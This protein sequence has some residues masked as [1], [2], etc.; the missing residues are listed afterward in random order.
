MFFYRLISVLIF[1][2][3]IPYSLFRI[4]KGKEDK[5]RIKE[6]FG[7]SSVKRPEGDLIWLHAVSV[8]ETNSVLILLDEILQ[9]DKKVNVLFT[10]TTLTSAAILA[11]KID[12]YNGRVIHQF[13]PFDSYFIIKKFLNFWKVKTAIFVESEIW[14]NLL[15]ESSKMGIK[16]VLVN[17]RMSDNSAQKWRLAKKIGFNIF[18]CFKIIFAQSLEDK[19]RLEKLTNN[20]VL[21]IGNLKSQARDL[22]VNSAELEKLKTQ[23]GKR[24][25]FLAAST[26][27]GE[28]QFVIATHQELK[29]DFPD[30]LTIL[31]PRHPNRTEEIKMLF[32]G[33][34]FS[35]RS[36]N[37][38]IKDA[39]EIYLANTLGELGTFYSLADFAFI[40]GSLSAVGGHNPFEPIKLEC[41]VISGSHVFNFKEIYANLVKYEACVMIDSADQ[42]TK[43]VREFLSNKKSSQVF[44]NKA[45]QVIATTGNIAAEIVKIIA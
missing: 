23:I 34:S 7:F 18:D 36:K 14:P 29:K 31:V 12:G 16:N 26:H 33:L 8:G 42:L 20:K 28:E 43:E 11:K 4:K 19:N 45:S 13:L 3:L 30:L 1:P 5:N 32:G 10:T 22:V 41:A 39:T 25:I 35:E 6:K 21:F 37:E 9:N 40:G 27:K 2:L 15:F 24:P 38:D 17:G 44:A